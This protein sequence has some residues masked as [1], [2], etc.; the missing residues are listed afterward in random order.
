MGEY[1][2]L[3]CTQNKNERSVKKVVVQACNGEKGGPA[4]RNPARKTGPQPLEQLFQCLDGYQKA[5]DLCEKK[6]FRGEDKVEQAQ[7]RCR[8]VGG[9]MAKVDAKAGARIHPVSFT[10]RKKV[11]VTKREEERDDKK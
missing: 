6:R 11:M 1:R 7:G 9:E 3:D 5:C 10:G 4:D 8:G 2:P